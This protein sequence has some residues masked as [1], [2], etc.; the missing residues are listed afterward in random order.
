MERVKGIEPS[1][2]AWEPHR[3]RAHRAAARS[4]DVPALSLVDP[5]G[6]WLMAR[7]W[8]GTQPTAR[9]RG[10]G[11]DQNVRRKRTSSR[12]FCPYPFCGVIGGPIRPR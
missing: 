10:A 11:R 12:T 9:G 1:L 6:P 7:Q 2:S 5:Y 4:P 8:H 3:T